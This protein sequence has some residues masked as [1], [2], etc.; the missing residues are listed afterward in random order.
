MFVPGCVHADLRAV[1]DKNNGY[2]TLNSRSSGSSDW[3]KGKDE[4]YSRTGV[5]RDP[6]RRKGGK[7]PRWHRARYLAKQMDSHGG[8]GYLQHFISKYKFPTSAEED[9]ETRSDESYLQ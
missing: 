2:Q 4:G 9:A 5:W 7:C 6:H 1:S 3:W 8:D